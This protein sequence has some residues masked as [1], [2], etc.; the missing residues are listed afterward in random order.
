MHGLVDLVWV[1]LALVILGM[2]FGLLQKYV[3]DVLFLT[4]IRIVVLVG[5][6]VW[7]MAYFFGVAMPWG[8]HGHP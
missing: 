8:R 2:A 3:T 5:V 1:V 7:I 4:L 6:V